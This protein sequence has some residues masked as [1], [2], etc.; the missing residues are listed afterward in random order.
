MDYLS[1]IGVGGVPMT[2]GGVSDSFQMYFLSKK[3]ERLI[4]SGGAILEEE[5]ELTG[6]DGSQYKGFFRIERIDNIVVTPGDIY[7]KNI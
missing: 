5:F 1:K 2:D 3:L 7:A 6:E 4:K